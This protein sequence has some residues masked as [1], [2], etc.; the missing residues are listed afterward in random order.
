MKEVSLSLTNLILGSKDLPN[1]MEVDEVKKSHSEIS[2]QKVIKIGENEAYP[3]V[4]YN[5]LGFERRQL[6]SVIVSSRNVRVQNSDGRGMI[7]QLNPVWTSDTTFAEDQF[8]LFFEV[9]LPPMGFGTYFIHKVD[10]TTPPKKGA[11]THVAQV[12]IK[13]ASGNIPADFLGMEVG[14]S[15]DEEDFSLSNSFVTVKVNKDTGLITNFGVTFS[16]NNGY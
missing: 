16:S 7:A 5:P 13:G 9:E 2:E 12:T 14:T 6:V 1:L 11:V 4:Y 3:V 10:D 8:E 15:W